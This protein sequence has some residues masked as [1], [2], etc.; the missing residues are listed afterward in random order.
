MD[1]V[2]EEVFISLVLVIIVMRNLLHSSTGRAIVSV[3]EDE[4]AASLS[5]SMLRRPRCWLS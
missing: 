2:A 1:H 5:V 4:Q 3:R